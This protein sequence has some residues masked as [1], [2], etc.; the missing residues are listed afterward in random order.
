[1]VS[2]SAHFGNLLKYKK[3]QDDE[4]EILAVN[5][6]KNNSN[7]AESMTIRLHDGQECN[8][9]LSFTDEECKEIID[10]QENYI[11]KLATVRYFGYTNKGMLRF[12]IVKTIDRNNY[13]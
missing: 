11:G 4:F 12:P 1:M 9:T 3:F 8:A 13:E 6:G 5:K 7:I 2:F 10:N